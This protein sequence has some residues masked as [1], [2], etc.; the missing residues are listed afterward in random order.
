MQDEAFFERDEEFWVE[1]EQRALDLPD[2]PDAVDGVTD[3][4]ML[5]AVH[6]AQQY[7]RVASL[8]RSMHAVAGR[9]GCVSDLIDRS[10]RLE[11]ASA[12]RITEYAAGELIGCATALTDRYSEALDA[13]HGARITDQHARFLVAIL[14]TVEADV[15]QPLVE[16]AVALAEELPAGSFRRA[17]RALVETERAASL[18]ERHERALQH[19]RVTKTTIGD[20]MAEVTALVPEVEADA[21]FDRITRFAKTM[22]GRHGDPDDDRTLD[23]ARAD[24]LCD[25]LIDGTCEGHPSA[26]RG[27]RA[28]VVVTVPALSLL[29]DD[30][31][32]AHPATVEGVGPIPID[33][34]RRLCGGS[35]RWMRVLTHPETGMVL[36]VGRERYDPPPELKRLVRWRAER[37]MAPGCTMPA[38]R[39]DIDHNIAWAH[40]GHTALWNNAPFCEGHHII[41]HHGGW[42]VRQLEGGVVEW[43]SPH[44]RRYLVEPERRVP[45]FRPDPEPAPF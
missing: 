10:L 27:I 7:E 17:L 29:D 6:T 36:S 9:V 8:R 15:A 5:I 43:I 21:I 30:H 4:A 41:K 24:V 13:L 2:P 40:G 22:T 42:T 31:A 39:C 19:R 25:L 37:C 35:A 14:D 16:Q 45:I 23:Q 33:V 3:V 11:L 1:L 12:L 38:A 44:G 34:A 20:G 26:A 32:A 28:S 18:T